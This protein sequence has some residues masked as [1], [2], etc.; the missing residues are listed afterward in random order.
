ME[1]DDLTGIWGALH[2]I[3]EVVL[4]SSAVILLQMRC[5]NT[6]QAL[7]YDILQL[8]FATVLT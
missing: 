7:S 3:S 2:I 8:L 5:S 1:E 4:I 6:C